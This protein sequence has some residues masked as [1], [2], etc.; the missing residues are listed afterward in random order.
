MTCVCCLSIIMTSLTLFHGEGGGGGGGGLVV[1]CFKFLIAL[2]Q[3]EYVN[4]T[5][6]NVITHY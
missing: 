6:S 5:I 2:G 4:I 1:F 3:Y